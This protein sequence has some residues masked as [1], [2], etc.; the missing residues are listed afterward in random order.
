MSM[1]KQKINYQ[2][3]LQQLR[4]NYKSQ[5]DMAKRLGLSPSYLSRLLNGKRDSNTMNQKTK[6]KVNQSFSYYSSKYAYQLIAEVTIEGEGLSYRSG[7]LFNVRDIEAEEKFFSNQLINDYPI[8][9]IHRFILRRR[10][11][12]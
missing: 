7:D 2:K 3:R 12:G 8:T 6:N 5:N 10:V 4:I 11:F 1:A 9:Q